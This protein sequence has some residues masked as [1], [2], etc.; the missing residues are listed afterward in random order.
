MAPNTPTDAETGMPKKKGMSFGTL[1]HV[2]DHDD[3]GTAKISK[4]AVCTVVSAV[5]SKFPNAL[6]AHVLAFQLKDI[7]SHSGFTE[8]NTLLGTSFCYDDV[9]RDLEDELRACF[10]NNLSLSGLAGFC[11]GGVAAVADMMKH[12]PSG[13]HALL[14]YG[15]HVGVDFDGVVGKVN[16][17]GHEGSGV[18][19]APASAAAVYAAQ[20]QAG[21]RQAG[22]PSTSNIL[23]MQ[24]TFVQAEV[25]KHATRLQGAPDAAVELPHCLYDCQTALMN[26][27]IAKTAS[28]LKPGQKLA[29]I[30]GVQVNTPEGTAEY[31]LPKRF[32]LMNHT[33]Q[34]EEDML[35]ELHNSSTMNTPGW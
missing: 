14:I 35:E 33:G 19:C 6:S 1:M 24:Q 27:L 4:E 29:V 5:Q 22:D 12:V 13:G 15:P 17:R 10:G 28:Q 18:C 7:L 16:R 21:E 3:E 2:Y 30:G 32:E 20:V 34:V 26:Q 23:D 25:L 9:N 31:F 11:F 8:A